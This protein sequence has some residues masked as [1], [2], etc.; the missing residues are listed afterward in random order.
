MSALGNLVSDIGYAA[1]DRGKTKTTVNVKN[2]E[3]QKGIDSSLSEFGGIQEKGQNALKDYIT[4]YL[5]GESAATTRTTQ[6]RAPSV[7]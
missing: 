1:G 6:K 3:L 2:K 5:A 7:R 4:K